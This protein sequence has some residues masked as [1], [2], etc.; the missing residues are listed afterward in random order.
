MHKKSRTF[1][2]N[3]CIF[4]FDRPEMDKKSFWK[5]TKLGFV[6]MNLL[7]AVAVVVVCIIVVV[8]CMKHYTEHGVEVT[9]PNVTALYIEE[10]RMTLAAEDLQIEVIDSTFSTKTPLG[11]I[12]E[13]TPAAGSKAKHGRVV[14][15]IQNARFRRPVVLPELRDASLRQAE[16]TLK[17]IGLVIDKIEYEPSTYKDIIL[18]V[19]ATSGEPILG[20]ASV[21]EGSSVVL[22]VGRGQG[23]E[24]VT[25]PLLTGKSLNEAR[26]WLLSAL[27][28]I[29]IVEY[30]VPPT[31]EDID[32]YVVYSQSPQNGM[33]VVEG[34]S[35]NV[36]MSKDIEKTII[37]DNEE[38][39]EEFF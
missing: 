22:I 36:K 37:N 28:T 29:G 26:S 31:D 11:T 12:V 1:A 2:Q 7:L 33:V 18:D 8:Q 32:Q 20:G 35:V 9:V 21:P 19:Q 13:Q 34:T 14:Y 23:T 16:A 39:E 24:E 3:L 27:L 38:D 15:V 4:L 25:V 6:L 5:E 10:A 17:S 30:D